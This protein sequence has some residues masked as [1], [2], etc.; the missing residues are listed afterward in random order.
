MSGADMLTNVRGLLTPEQLQALLD[1]VDIEG[2]DPDRA[3]TKDRISAII[4]PN[5]SIPPPEMT[6]WRV[7]ELLSAALLVHKFH[8]K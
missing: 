3:E 4:E 8:G 2:L 5:P 7:V 6:H 1:L